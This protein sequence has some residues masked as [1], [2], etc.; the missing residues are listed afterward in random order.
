MFGRQTTDPLSLC[1]LI[2]STLSVNQIVDMA[3]QIRLQPEAEYETS[4]VFDITKLKHLPLFRKLLE[5]TQFPDM[6][7]CRAL[8][9][10]VAL[11]GSEPESSLFTKRYKPFLLTP[12]QLDSQAMLRRRSML[13]KPPAAIPPSQLQVLLNETAE[14]VSLGFLEGPL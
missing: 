3:E 5:D 9:E 11:V 1:T 13:E 14:E 4:H 6:D 10:G 7:V 12:E 2:P 8:E